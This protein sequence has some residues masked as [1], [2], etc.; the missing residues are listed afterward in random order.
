[1]TPFSCKIENTE[2]CEGEGG[3]IM[4]FRDFIFSTTHL[5]FHPSPPTMPPDDCNDTIEMVISVRRP[6]KN[7]VKKPAFRRSNNY[8]NGFSF[9]VETSAL[10]LTTDND[11][12]SISFNHPTSPMGYQ[13]TQL[14]L[15]TAAGL[16][17]HSSPVSSDG[18]FKRTLEDNII[19][20]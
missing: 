8:Y 16:T 14:H 5:L 7:T 20:E 10:T 3:V 9:P 1:M 17:I 15:V 12:L 11:H 19:L 4:L 13:L 18:R 6:V 2:G